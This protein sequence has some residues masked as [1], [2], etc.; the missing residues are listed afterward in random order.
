[1]YSIYMCRHNLTGQQH[2]EEIC[3]P[4]KILSNAVKKLRFLSKERNWVLSGIISPNVYTNN[5]KNN[6]TVWCIINGF[7]C[8]FHKK[9]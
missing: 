7:K 3:F 1:M 9:K 8:L 2:S 6:F 5:V 4:S